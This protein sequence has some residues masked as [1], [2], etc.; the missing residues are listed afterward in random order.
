MHTRSGLRICSARRKNKMMMTV[1]MKTKTTEKESQVGSFSSSTTTKFNVSGNL[2]NALT[3]LTLIEF[4][5]DYRDE[6]I[7]TYKEW[8]RQRRQLFNIS[9][10]S[11]LTINIRHYTKCVKINC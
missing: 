8:L 10:F 7:K 1:M 6:T 11:M 4:R 2:N 3:Y 5:D 9:K